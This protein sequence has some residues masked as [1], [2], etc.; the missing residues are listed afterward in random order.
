MNRKDD[1]MTASDGKKIALSRWNPDGEKPLRGVIQ[2]AHGKGEHRKRYDEFARFLAERGFLV[3]ANDHRGHGDTIESPGE[4]G[5]FPAHEGW[6]RVVHDLIE[7]KNSLQ[8]EFPGVPFFLFG[9]SMGSFLMRNVILE[10]SNGVTGVILSGTAFSQGLLGRLGMIMSNREIRKNGPDAPSKVLE[11]MAFGPYNKPFRPNRTAF[12]WLSRDEAVVDAYVADPLCG[13]D[14]SGV[15]F[16]ELLKGLTVIC[17][18]YRVNLLPP[19][20]PI[21]LFSGALDPVGGFTKAVEKT[22]AQYQKAGIKDLTQK[23]YPEGRHEML[24]ELNREE[25]YA[26]VLAWIEGRL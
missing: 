21:Y 8:V 14:C 11:N 17:D 3:T 9:H 22:R 10:D 2:I 13:F 16:R 6:S 26:D 15:F 24:N 19:E 5:S 1:T 25:V 23:F 20:L 4:K 12:D 18:Q 7:L